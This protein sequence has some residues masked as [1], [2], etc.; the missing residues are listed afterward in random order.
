MRA[1]PG[2]EVIRRGY[3]G[4]A[5]SRPPPAPCCTVQSAEYPRELL[6]EQVGGGDLLGRGLRHVEARGEYTDVVARL[7]AADPYRPGTAPARGPATRSVG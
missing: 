6:D 7:D 5:R 2:W 1:R 4:I 3:P